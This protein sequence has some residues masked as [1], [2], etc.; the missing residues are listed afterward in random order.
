VRGRAVIP[1]ERGEIISVLGIVVAAWQPE[2]IAAT[3]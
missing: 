2:P 1:G 3:L